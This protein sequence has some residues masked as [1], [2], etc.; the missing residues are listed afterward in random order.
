[1]VRTPGMLWWHAGHVRMLS[2]VLVVMLAACGG[3]TVSA[4]GGDSASESESSATESSSTTSA[5]SFD[6]GTD[7]SDEPDCG[8]FS[9]VPT[10]VHP[11][12]MLIVDVSSS[13]RESVDHDQNPMTPVVLRW[14][15]A[16]ALLDQ[17]I[18]D[19]D[20]SVWFG[21]QRVPSIGAC[22]AATVDDPNCKD[23]DVCLVDS[24]PEIE[25]GELH[26]ESILAALPDASA[27][28]LEIVGGSPIRAAW[29]AARDHLLAQPDPIF[30]GIVLITDGGAN[31]SESSLPEAV[32][33][34]DDELEALVS[35]GFVLHGIPTVVVGVG[36]G[37]QPSLPAQPDSP[38]ADV[39]A[40]LNDLG[41]AGGMPWNGGNEPRKF[42]DA[43]QPDELMLAL[44]PG[45]G[46]T[47]CTV[48]LTYVEGGP[49]EPVQIP[50]MVIE[51]NG[52]DV[53]YVNDC[54]NE[55]GWAW[56]EEGIIL[57]FCGSYCDGFKDGTMAFE[58][59]YGCPDATTS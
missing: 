41:V 34:F 30:S 28:P 14:A 18:P 24:S 13:M 49:P 29:V 26:G 52:Q 47:D 21:L 19:L 33:V 40:A 56:I 38:G 10:Y 46:V 44:D 37:E 36:V 57:T 35:D 20:A 51:A 2:F 22:P 58:G 6:E 54:A 4:S 59:D 48:D 1:V 42:F 25:I 53:P 17:I 27:S 23:A 15:T 32:E 45:G 8:G 55:D 11:N 43:S 39:Y 5:D 3:P 12:V 31:C 7:S 16:R 50:D 9:V